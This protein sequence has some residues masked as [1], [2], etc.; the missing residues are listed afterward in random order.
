MAADGTSTGAADEPLAANQV[1]ADTLKIVGSSLLG[2]TVGCAQCHDHRYDPIPQADYYRLRAVFEPALDPSHWRRPVAAPGLALHGR[3][4][5]QA[6]AI[7]AEAAEAS[8][9]RRRQD[10]EVRRGGAREGAGEVPRAACG[11]SFAPP[12]RRRR[13]SATAEQKRLLASHPSV[14]ITAGVLYQYN[15]AAAD[16]LKKDQERGHRQ[17]RREA[18]R[19]FRQRARRGARRACPRRTIFHRGD[20]R[21]PTQAVAAGRPD[22]S[23]RPKARGS[24]SPT[25]TPRCPPRAAGWPSPG[26]SSSGR[27]SAGRPR[28][29]QPDL[30]ASL[31]PRTG[32]HARR[33]R[34]AGHAPDAS[35]S[36]STGWP[37]SWSARAGA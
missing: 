15:Q 16:E 1:V 21:Q 33:L 25:R 30:A 35:R 22:A 32:R 23:P 31:R 34:R 9:G 24:R 29:G 14:N 37:T 7:E 3:R 26:T 17:A 6:A 13:R 28:A 27:P 8:E 11:P 19:G 18:G 36:C 4:P 12:A 5:G 10:R 2:L 20:H